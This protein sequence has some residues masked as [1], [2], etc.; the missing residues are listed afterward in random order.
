MTNSSPLTVSSDQNP[1]SIPEALQKAHA[2]WNAGQVDQAEMFCQRV[3]S[4]WPGQSDALHLMGVMAHAYGN[5]DLAIDHLRKACQAPRTPAVYFS[6]LAEMLRQK[7]L[8]AEAEQAGRKSVAIDNNLPSAWNNLGIILQ[9][10]GQYE[11]SKMCLERV[12]TYDPINAEA[13]NNLA[14]TC[15]RMSLFDKAEQYWLKALELKPNYA[16]PYSNLSNLFNDRGEWDKA[17]EAARKAI[18]INPQLIDAYINLSALET[19]RSNHNEALRWQNAL[20]SFAPLHSTGLA[21]RALTLKQLEK[22]DEALN[23]AQAAVASNPLSDEAHNALGIVLQSL[24]RFDEALESFERAASLP[25]TAAEKALV[26]RALLYMEQGQTTEAE[27]AYDRVVATF[28]H[29]ISA[30]FNRA[31]L[32]S[33]KSDDNAIDTLQ[34]LLSK[35]TSALSLNEQLMLHFT[36]GKAHMDQGYSEKAFQYLNTGNALKRQNIHYDSKATLTWMKEIETIFSK[37]FLDNM[38]NQGVKGSMPIFILGM[39]RSGTSLIEQILAS[40]PAVYGAGELS[41]LQR[42]VESVGSYPAS[43][44]NFTGETLQQLGSAYLAKVNSLSKGH[45]FVVDKMPA[46]FLYTGL[47]RLILP[48]AH[49]IHCRRDPVDTCLSCYTKLFTGEQSF[50]YNLTEL[51]EFHLGYQSLMTHFRSFMPASHFLE[52]DY[53]SVVE[54]LESEAK[55]ILEFLGLT[56]DPACLEFYKTKRPVRTASVN[57]VRQPVYKTSAGRWRKHEAQLSELIRTLAIRTNK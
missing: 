55:R 31:D 34:A 36:L 45:A 27:A 42:I 53:E 5:L 37:S 17:A 20:L 49:I 54:D 40:H 18:E 3:L 22:L 21:S 50:T 56:W 1:M 41:E 47:I 9:E 26:N 33:F 14:N 13:H 51:G 15:K 52:V 29:S 2:H 4:V 46:N 35:G 10:A 28:P 11:E 23:S 7:G 32:K 6:N 38:K 25:G 24:N 44:N 12:I 30:W 8:L 57:Q 43:V 39:P 16:E 19:A 48:E